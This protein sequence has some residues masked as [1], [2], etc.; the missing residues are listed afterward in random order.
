MIADDGT[1]PA[2]WE[3]EG[4]IGSAVRGPASDVRLIMFTSGSTG[5]PKGVCLG[6]GALEAAARMNVEILQLDAARRSLT[7]V[8]LFDYYGLIQIHSH[9]LARSELILGPS[10]AFPTAV[11]DAIRD[12]AVTDLVGVP[13]GL[14]RVFR[15]VDAE[16]APALGTLRTVTSSSEQLTEDVLR[17]IFAVAPAAR[18]VD[19]YGLTEAGRACS[20]VITP[21]DGASTSIGTPSRGVH[22]AAGASPVAPEELV[23]EGPN[24]M[25]GYL[26][27]VTDDGGIHFEPTACVRTGDLGYRDEHGAIHL[28]G[29][30]DH[31]LN[32]HGTLVHPSQ[33][34]TVA[35]ASS[36]VADARAR[37]SGGADSELILELVLD[38]PGA[39]IDAV[40][41]A[42]R[43]ELAPGLVPQQIALVDAIPHTELGSKTVRERAS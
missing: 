9:L 2:G 34:E 6:A 29:R 8:P 15:A 41:K 39:D 40:R 36:G 31:L 38:D 11:V 37:M 10:V 13:F 20:R 5:E 12:G 3:S 1:A 17:A 32:V 25:L 24:V 26:S 33:I 16:R 19:I 27:D 4:D 23:I 30:S 43:R 42:L 22:I 18:V 14:R 21:G 35:F 7:T 28:A